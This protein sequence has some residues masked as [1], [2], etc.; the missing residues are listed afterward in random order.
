MRAEL[1]ILPSKKL[2]RPAVAWLVAGGDPQSWLNQLAQW[3]ISLDSI[4]LRPIPRTINDSIPIAAL[5]TLGSGIKESRSKRDDTVPASTTFS[6]K[7]V[8]P[9]GRVADRLFIPVDAMISPDVSD[10]ELAALLPANDADFVWHPAAGLVRIEATE[11]L[12]LVDLLAKP[13]EH[14]ADWSCAV[15]GVVFRSRLISIEPES[16]YSAQEIIDRSA[17]D[18]GSQRESLDQLPPTPDEWFG[19]AVNQ[20]TKPLRETW[21]WMV[22]R[23]K[24][25]PPEKP[26]PSKSDSST[27]SHGRTGGSS[28]LGGPLGFISNAVSFIGQGLGIA[29]F[30]LA[31]AGFGAAKFIGGLPG[32]S[33]VD[34]IARNREIDRLMHLLKTDPDAGL[35]FA[36]PM[37]NSNDSRGVA[38]RSNQ[39]VSRDIDFNLSGL[40]IGGPAD[41]WD[42]PPDQQ[43]MLLQQY[44]ELAMR[45][46]RLGR[47]R[48]AAYIY[49]KLLD[50][51]VAAAGALE[52]GRHYREAAVLY[53]DRLN[54]PVDAAKCLERGGLLDE[55]AELYVDVGL[56]EQAA[57]LYV[58][59]DRKD[60]AVRLLRSFAEQLIANG[61]YRNASR[62]LH[63]K[64]HD[65]DGALNALSLGW[66]ESPSA[67]S[68]LEE[69]FLLMGLHN[70]HDE[71]LRRIGQLRT[72]PFRANVVK[73]LARGL[74]GVHETYPD[75]TV[76]STAADT[77]QIVVARALSRANP[78]DSTELL[79]SIRRLAP[80]DRLLLRDCDRFVAS[81]Q[82]PIANKA[83]IVKKTRGIEL[84]STFKLRLENTAWRVAKSAGK[85]VYIAGY[86]KGSLVLQRIEWDNT[87][88][89]NSR[90]FWAGISDARLLFLEVFPG[91]PN[92]EIVLHPIG[93]DAINKRGLPTNQGTMIM[94][95][96]PSWTTRTTRALAFAE[97]GF[98]WQISG[99]TRFCEISCTSPTGERF[100]AKEIELPW[101]PR[102][103]DSG[104]TTLFAGKGTVRIGFCSELC[105]PILDQ[106]TSKEFLTVPHTRLRR[107]ILS[108]TGSRVSDKTWLCALFETGGIVINDAD[109][110]DHS[111]IAEELDSPCA[112][113]LMDGRLIVAGSQEVHA[114]Q[115]V[116]SRPVLIYKSTLEHKPIAVTTTNKL[117]E[118]AVFSEN[119]IVQIMSIEGR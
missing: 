22:K 14:A 10:T 65:V 51:V 20:W 6:G 7:L 64:L 61:D 89:Q 39:L 56:F 67:L 25:K 82:K 108:L 66:P 33:F 118:F 41:L 69:S 76:K 46:M 72:T 107:T 32:M 68:C 26:E 57:D 79:L 96:S 112:T 103:D 98:G 21:R 45:E 109:H 48:R 23:L 1:K 38:Q 116:G 119:G 104:Q 85:A 42:I 81:R 62:I 83:P 71:A 13:A 17:T 34:Q 101:N 100:I 44:R 115:I 63:D 54:R 8:Q 49:A 11:R 29:T 117:G 87:G 92:R 70:R 86:G 80:Q 40:G 12:R 47:H 55:A 4:E 78:A 9:Y 105:R 58:R 15:A 37:S 16:P 36:L 50:D 95:G 28:W 97:G 2:E 31:A 106:N 94:A 73:L 114:Y 24:R 35:R 99:E 102:N 88:Q 43:L 52:G 60:E 110:D 91:E 74:S 18:I 111:S 53:R 19:G 93:V 75:Q 77:T 59:L 5:V 113:F 3:G 90:A 30:S 27:P 84:L